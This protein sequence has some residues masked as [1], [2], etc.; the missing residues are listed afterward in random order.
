MTVQVQPQGGAL[1]APLHSGGITMADERGWELREG[2]EIVPGVHTLQLLGRARRYEAYLAWHDAMLAVVVVKILRPDRV[3]DRS[4]L[5]GLAAEAQALQTLDHP[6]LMRSFGGVL[7]G[8]RPHLVLEF[9]EGPRLSTLLRKYGPLAIEQAIPLAMQ[10]SSA[11]HYMS[12]RGWVHLDVKPKNIIMGGPPRL[13]DLSVAHT[14]SEAATLDVPVGTD[15][16]MAPEQCEPG[17]RGTPGSPADVWGLGVTLFEA[18][19]GG[20]PFGKGNDE[21]RFPQLHR[22]RLP[23]PDEVPLP[24]ARIVESCLVPQPEARP[25]ALEVFQALEPLMAVLP[26]RPII[27]RLKPRL[28]SAR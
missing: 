11:I 14:L 10:L 17:T 8:A 2:D 15:A 6:V 22:E 18:L 13:I 24:L 26:T 4:A 1:G 27:G 19:V 7:D 28:R 16:Y 23:F 12:V 21:D 5:R 9:L 20:L 25:A 3:H